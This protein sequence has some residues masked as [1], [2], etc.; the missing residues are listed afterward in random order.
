MTSTKLNGHFTSFRCLSKWQRYFVF[1]PS[2]RSEPTDVKKA[3]KWVEG[4]FL[5]PVPLKPYRDGEDVLVTFVFGRNSRQLTNEE[6]R[7]NYN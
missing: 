2:L 3:A 5:T 1:I 4:V 6:K 7:N